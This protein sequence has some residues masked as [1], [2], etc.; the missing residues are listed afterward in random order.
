M[1]QDH[2]S[3]GKKK[4]RVSLNLLLCIGVALGLL[5]GFCSIAPVHTLADNLSQIF[6]NLLKLVSLPMILLSVMSTISGMQNFAEL[7]SLGRRTLVYAVLT[8]FIAGMVALGLYLLIRPTHPM[9]DAVDAASAQ[10]SYW[11]LALQIFP[12]NIASVF[13]EY[14]VVGLMLIAIVMGLSIL[15]LPKQQKETLHGFFS[16]LFSALLKITHWLLY[17]M[18][19]GVWAFVTML[20]RDL[21]VDNPAALQSFGLYLACVVGANLIQGLIVLPTLLKLRGGS[22]IRLFR[23]MAPAL[24]VAFFTRSSN[25]ALPVTLDAIQGRAGVSKRVSNFT[26]PLCSTINMNGC[27]AF[28]LT[29]VL[30]VGTSYGL[31]FSMFD[32]LLWVVIATIAAMGNAGVAMG[33]Y[34]LSGALLSTLNVPLGLFGMILPVYTFIDMMET[35]VNVWS[36]SCIATIV[37]KEEADS[38]AILE[39]KEEEQSASIIH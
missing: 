35:S 37:D 38:A 14:N 31:T 19:I 1:C 33:C 17:L 2:L 34:F 32:M 11:S 16:A 5:C 15:T 36:D 22:P 6:V 3:I 27:A 10:A 18:P 23:A 28:I 12:D 8:T 21:L 24:A 9:P 7:R 30:F 39:Q 20:T 25:S 13:L 26:I 4:R 29:T